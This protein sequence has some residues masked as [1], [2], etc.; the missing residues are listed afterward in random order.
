[1]IG[2]LYLEKFKVAMLSDHNV[3]DHSTT[4]VK[5]AVIKI[6]PFVVNDKYLQAEAHGCLIFS[7]TTVAIKK[8]AD[9]SVREYRTGRQIEI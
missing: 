6:L 4:R 1:M 5:M 9:F 8:A 3:H 2:T 7:S